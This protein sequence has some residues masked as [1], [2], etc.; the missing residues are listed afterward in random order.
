MIVVDT[1]ALIAIMSREPEAQA[2]AALIRKPEPTVITAANFLETMIVAS[3]RDY[4]RE[5]AHFIET[6]G[7]EIYP[8]DAS[9]AREAVTAHLRFGRGNH[10]ARLNYGDCFSYALAKRLGCPLLYVGH[11]FRRTDL[12]PAH[13]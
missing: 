1:S 12:V 5:M 7:I 10:P 13:A 4:G 11:D 2:C 6:M 3:K 9:L 8:V